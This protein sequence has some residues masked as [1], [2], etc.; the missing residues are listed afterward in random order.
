MSLYSLYKPLMRSLLFAM[1]AEQAHD[2]VLRA[3]SSAASSGSVLPW[4]AQ[5]VPER[6]VQA[7]GLEFAHPL[8]LAA[9]LD[10]NAEAVDFFASLGFSHVEVGTVTP[11][12]QSGNARPRMFRMVA[13]QGLINRMGFNNRGVDY[14]VGNL[15]RRR[16]RIIVG[17]S[18]GKN[19]AT[20]LDRATAD[21]LTCFNRVC[22][23]CDY[24]SVN[25]SCPNTAQL[26]E[27][28]EAE[29]LNGLLGA[30]KCAQIAMQGQLGKYVPLVV[31]ISPD[32]DFDGIATICKCVLANEIDAIACT[33]STVQR[34]MVKGMEHAGEW[35]GLSGQPLRELSTRVLSLVA[36][37]VGTRIPI[38]G[39]GGIN[40]VVSAREKLSHGA[41]LIQLYTG[42]IYEGPDLIRKIV[43]NL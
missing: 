39:I 4:M 19:E 43:T 15:R 11:E 7:M 42:L 22:P 31:K 24:V 10:K 20:P 38:I 35:G 6:R 13:S 1:D 8:G 12:P 18:I 28:Q 3:A 27:L 9:G 37:H 30:L 5:K 16:S 36:S 23:H 2:M 34:D 40:D 41:S 26:T 21:Y 29:R 14:L 25:V 33:N 17:V 32:L